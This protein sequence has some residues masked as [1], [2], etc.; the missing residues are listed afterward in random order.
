ME[1]YVILIDTKDTSQL[2]DRRARP[3]SH[4][5]PFTPVIDAISSGVLDRAVRFRPRPRDVMSTGTGSRAA[6]VM[7]CASARDVRC[8]QK[9]SPA[10]Q[11]VET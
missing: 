10:A 11:L 3:P 5:F 7:L 1:L 8:A 9:I 6:A 4:G 2:I